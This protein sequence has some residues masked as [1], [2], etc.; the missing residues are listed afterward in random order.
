MERTMMTRL[1]LALAFIVF[2]I[3]PAR[4]QRDAKVPDPDPEFE[5]K[6]LQLAPGFEINLYAADPLL[7]KP[8]QMN[9]DAAGRL[10]V[11]SSE[12]YPQIKPGQKAN[13]KIIVLEDTKGVGKADKVTVF[14]D[15]LLI[16]TGIEPGDGGVYVADSTDILHLKDTKGTGKADQRR[17][18]LSGFGTED[19][20]HIIHTFRWGHDGML[21]FNQSVYIHSHVETPHGVRRLNAGGIWQFRP[22][23]MQLEVFVRG[24]WNTWGH[25]FDD[26]GQSFITDGAGGEGINYGIPGAY[27]AASYNPPRV[28]PGLNPG[29]PKYCGLEIVTGRHVPPE[30]V[31]SLVT[32]DF[33]GH[34]VCR[35]TVKDDGSGYAAVRQ[36]DLVASNHPAFRPIDVKMGPDGAIYIADWYNPIIQHGEVDF[37]DPR[38][39]HT[40]GRIWRITAK[41]RP[42]APRPKLVDATTED[43]LESLKAPE[44]YTRHFAKRVMKER[45]AEK[46]K[47]VLDAWAKKIDA[48]DEHLLLEAMWTYQSLNVPEPALLE[49]LLKASDHRVRAAAV[50]VVPHWK[51]KLTNPEAALEARIADEHPQVR[52][53]AVRAL[54]QFP[55][56]KSAEVALRALDK[57]MDKF[58][59]YGLFLTAREL[60]PLWLPELQA[61]KLDF[62]G[63][64]QHIVFALQAAGSASG[65][66]PLVKLLKEG[67]VAKDR[68]EQALT[69]LAS[70][71]GPAE[72]TLVLD[73]ALAKEGNTPGRQA[74]LLAALEQAARQRNARPAGDLVR[75]EALLGSDNAGVRAVAVRTVGA[76][77]VETLRPKLLELARADKTDGEVRE[78]AFEG[79]L[80]LGGPATKTSVE[81]LADKEKNIDVRRQAV[82][83]LASLDVTGAAT[84][85]IDLFASG[86]SDADPGSVVAA[87]LERKNGAKAL[88]TALGE[89]NLPSDVAKLGVR[90]AR[91]SARAEP[92]LVDAFTKA[93]NLTAPLRTLS[94]KEM[95]AMV[96]DVTKQGDPA[97]GEAIFRRKDQSCLKCHAIGGAGGQVGPDIASIGASAQIDYLIDSILLPSKQI[98]ENYHSMVVTTKDGRFLTGIK[99]REN[100]QE[101]VL[102][103]AEDK[104]IVI[105]TKSIEEK[106]NGGSLMP[107]GLADSLTRAELIDLIRFLS[108]LGKEGPYAVSKARLVRRWEAREATW[109][110]A[111]SKVSGELGI[112]DI[113]QSQKSPGAARCQLDVSTPGKVKLRIQAPKGTV[114]T[115]DDKAV[116]LKT[117]MDVDL[118]PGIHTLAFQVEKGARGSLRVELDDVVGSRARV[119]VVNGK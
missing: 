72:L 56:V 119:Q 114:M 61:G 39:D 77:K 49:R 52:L 20:H 93:G 7:A 109:V 34:R 113:P 17:V 66:Q 70:L 62:G 75:V 58:L 44:Q 91:N 87:F 28:L 95:Q 98:K 3:T 33:R 57:P 1:C 118:A 78:A 12:V 8:I 106:A 115:I 85:A 37:R 102:R 9:F 32:H 14:A 97:R 107:E 6:T 5:R 24:L 11:A 4:A 105:P 83:T 71:G 51:T 76:W 64:P 2:A 60:A 13:D 96:A 117:E 108:E 47:P 54:V 30:Y 42:L 88:I 63:N 41:G 45:G 81:E 35:F 15:G 65:V 103:N 94:P 27:Y 43:L 22:E 26:Y 86:P 110:P 36:A 101:L 21:Y 111:Y 50:R 10:W 73:R 38:R 84:R 46:V 59:D 89:K 55:S 18:V 90:A 116:E 48:K 29:S 25:H 69:M 19:T 80:L 112:E 100:K 99:V 79:L 31:G 40:H 92:A 68:E 16:P 67:K 74:A 23:T 53:E 104:E 82:I